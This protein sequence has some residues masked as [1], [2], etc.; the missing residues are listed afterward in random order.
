MFVVA[1]VGRCG[2]PDLHRA[3]SCY[4]V[5]E[6]CEVGVKLAREMGDKAPKKHI[7]EELRA[8][9]AYEGTDEESGEGFNIAIAELDEA[10]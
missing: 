8:E 3:V 5:D 1:V 2:F 7:K 6:A 9:M 4:S 10:K